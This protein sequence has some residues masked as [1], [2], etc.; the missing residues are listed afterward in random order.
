MDHDYDTEIGGH[1]ADERLL[2]F[3]QQ[4]IATLAQLDRNELPTTPYRCVSVDT[5]GGP[6]DETVFVLVQGRGRH[7]N[8]VSFR[9][10]LDQDLAKGLCWCRRFSA[11]SICEHVCAALDLL[12]DSVEREL[13]ERG[14]FTPATPARP[15][16]AWKQD[17][18]WLDRALETA[19]TAK[20]ATQEAP[21]RIVWRLRLT[22]YGPQLQAIEQSR[23]AAGGFTKGRKISFQRLRSERSLWTRPEVKAVI[24]AIPMSYANSPRGGAVESREAVLALVNSRFVTWSLQPTQAVSIHPAQLGLRLESRDDDALALVPTFGD[25]PLSSPHSLRHDILVLADGDRGGNPNA[26]SVGRVDPQVVELVQQ[27]SVRSQI[28]PKAARNELIGRLERLE[29]FLPIAVS[30]DLIGDSVESDSRLRLALSPVDKGISVQARVRPTVHAD[31]IPPGYEIDLATWEDGKRVTVRRDPTAERQQA[32]DLLAPLNL[33]PDD[34]GQEHLTAWRW[35][36]GL[37]DALDLVYALQEHPDPRLVIEWP[38]GEPTSVS[39]GTT[40]QLKVQLE[41]TRDWF[42]LRGEV[43]VDG[44]SVPLNTILDGL[45]QGDR[46]IALDGG[47]W[48]QLSRLLCDK[49][50]ALLDVAHPTRNGDVVVDPTAAPVVKEL[51]DYA[52]D[53][54]TCETWRDLEKRL[55]S[56]RDVSTDLPETLNATLRPYQQDGFA[57]LKR[58]STWGVGACLADDM[59]LGKTVQAI[60]ILLTRVD[61]GPTLV[62]APTSVGANWARELERFA[63]S[64]RPVVYRETDRDTVLDSL[65]GNDVVIVSYDMARIDAEKLHAKEWGTLVFDEAQQVKNGQTKTARALRDLNGRWRLAL[66]GTPIEN[67]LGDLWSL[68]RLI[69]PGVFGSW[70]LFKTKY[71]RPIERENNPKRREAL[72]A[73]IRPFVLRRTKNEVL[74]DLPPRTDVHV[75]V[76]LGEAER[77]LYDDARL[78]AI[79]EITTSTADEDNR[80]KILAA[81]TRLRQL[82]CHPGLVDAGWTQGSGKLKAFLAIVDELRDG[83]H[84]ALVFSQFTRHLGILRALLESRGI[85]YAYL[86]GRTPAKQRQSRVDAFQ[87]GEGDLFLISLKAGGKGLNLTGADYVIHMDPWWNPAAEDQAS[88]RAHRIGQLRPVTVYR[89]VAKDTIE[90][91]ILELHATKR[92]LVSGI[93][94]GGDQAA[95]L[96]T[97]D[98]LDLIRTGRTNAERPY[99]NKVT[100]VS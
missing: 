99:V 54:K 93:L 64:L 27:L 76:E 35:S 84:R 20:Q 63:P 74:P 92:D 81:L 71:A 78:Q 98:L 100:P 61:E 25:L 55:A 39:R 8:H 1:I 57:W 52:G 75:E 34:D 44:Q 77:A 16:D 47:R 38:D 50:N 91:Q 6:N 73:V 85:S 22:G 65:T 88:D 33:T 40:S 49:L 95:K 96:S 13:Q 79:A 19:T 41:Q 30:D 5:E 18:F 68:F 24:D 9:F 60:A 80:F 86:D 46:Y 59:G 26:V 51:L 7:P 14:L 97:D 32:L 11:A 37:E 94:S 69:S 72:A 87:A 10:P 36:L 17:L 2:V 4:L 43:V 90:E 3:H 29:R 83:G 82:A 15:T 67:H 42:G 56:A 89:L 31:A 23:R 28:F 70:E 58:L 53:V 48:L 12:R 21:S 45:L 62:V 66:T